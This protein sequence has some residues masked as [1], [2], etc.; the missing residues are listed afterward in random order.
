MVDTIFYNK[1]S[2]FGSEEKLVMQKKLPLFPIGLYILCEG[3][4]GQPHAIHKQLACRVTI[5]K[6]EVT[7]RQDAD[8]SVS[9]A[10]SNGVSRGKTVVTGT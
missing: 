2:P 7:R 10:L 3:D 4:L 9:T 6:M 5:G 8:K 1:S